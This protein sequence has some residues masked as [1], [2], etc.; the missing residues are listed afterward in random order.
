ERRDR[1]SY[2]RPHPRRDYRPHGGAAMIRPTPRAVLIFVCGVPLALFWLIFAPGQWPWSLAYG[3]VVLVLIAADAA[4]ALPPAALR[5]TAVA[6]ETLQI[7]ETGTLGVTIASA[8]YGRPTAFEVLAEQRGEA[9][10]PGAL[11]TTLVPGHDAQVAIA[12]A[13]RQRGKLAI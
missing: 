7:G 2:A 8:P 1:G 5:V 13:P 12:L 3:V 10:P 6:P 4:W 11:M 9:D